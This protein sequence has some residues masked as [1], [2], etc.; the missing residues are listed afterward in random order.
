[1]EDLHEPLLQPKSVAEQNEA[2]HLSRTNGKQTGNNETLA[3]IQA[4]DIRYT[5]L[6]QV[7]LPLGY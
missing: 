1:M 4:L 3:E 2:R 5:K 6:L 7:S